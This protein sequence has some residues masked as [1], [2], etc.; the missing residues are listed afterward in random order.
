MNGYVNRYA[1]KDVHLFAP[2]I[3]TVLICPGLHYI[4]YYNKNNVLQYSFLIYTDFFPV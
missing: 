3:L 1:L 2:N 4:T